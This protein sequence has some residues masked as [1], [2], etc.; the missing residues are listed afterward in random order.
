MS[1]AR[2]IDWST[3]AQRLG[4]SSE[5]EMWKEL[6]E[7]KRLTLA[8]MAQRFDVSNVTIRDAF[9]RCGVKIRSRGGPNRHQDPRWPSDEELR[10]EVARVGAVAVATRLGFSRSAVHKR[11]RRASLRIGS[12]PE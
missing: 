8:D 11:V 5:L 3:T 2:T 12:T 7:V 1:S 10:E 6:Y 4:Y 9:I